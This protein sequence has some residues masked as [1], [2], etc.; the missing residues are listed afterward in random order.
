MKVH[1][2]NHCATTEICTTG[3]K[4]T[5]M[6]VCTRIRNKPWN[7]ND[8]SSPSNLSIS[9][10]RTGEK[11]GQASSFVGM[12]TVM[13]INLHNI[14]NKTWERECKFVRITHG[15]AFTF[16]RQ[17]WLLH[18]PQSICFHVS[19]TAWKI[20]LQTLLPLLQGHDVETMHLWAWELHIS[21]LWCT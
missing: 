7:N 18:S 20:F 15:T 1:C 12:S 6:E 14:R 13:Y 4:P 8:K 3:H 9:L 16:K 2:G 11:R 10:H 5:R 17:L 19:F 21:A